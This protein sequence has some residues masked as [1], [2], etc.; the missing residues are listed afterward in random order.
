MHANRLIPVTV[1]LGLAL[2]ACSDDE[3]QVAGT[4]A[5][6]TSASPVTTASPA[7]TT[8]MLAGIWLNDGGPT[9]ADSLL[10]SLGTDASMAFDNGG[11]LDTSPCVG[12]TYELVED[13]MIFE[14]ARSGCC[15]SGD[16]WTF[17][18]NLS[19]EG[20]LSTVITEDGTGNCQTGMGNEWNWTRVS[21]QSSAGADLTGA[22]PD[23]A[24]SHQPSTTIVQ[25]IWLL[26][27][28]GQL[29]R[30]STDGTYAMD[31]A[32]TLLAD[33]ADVGSFA[34]DGTT[35]TLTSDGS[36]SCRAGATHVLDEIK[37]GE[38]ALDM[39]A[40]RGVGSRNECSI[41]VE[42]NQTWIRLSP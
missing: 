15:P 37:I 33:P 36:R 2:L 5:P 3:A 26:E 40:M 34:I 28:S 18:A 21:P 19:E 27:G 11:F 22:E 17:R 10:L 16:S 39:R 14:N 7:L 30:L 29:L 1:A 32:G 24:V 25:G 35:L 13:A 6:P 9:G 8:D 20:R 38:E 23:A 31:N 12:G 42:G 41:H 4:S